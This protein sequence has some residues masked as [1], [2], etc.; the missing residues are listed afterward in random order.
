[1]LLRI[2]LRPLL[3]SIR[4]D[5]YATKVETYDLT[6]FVT[7]CSQV[8]LICMPPS[9]ENICKQSTQYHFVNDFLYR[10][11]NTEEANSRPNVTLR[12]G[13]RYYPGSSF[14][15]EE[16]Y[17]DR[18]QE[19]APQRPLQFR[20]QQQ[21]TIRQR[22]QQ[23]AQPTQQHV[24]VSSP[25]PTVLQQQQPQQFARQSPNQVFHSSEEINIPLQQRRPVQLQTQRPNFQQQQQNE[26]DFRRK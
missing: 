16:E 1:M 19:E 18:E 11:V 26:F 13:D 8:H 22:I 21:P 7:S 12:Y 15:A 3:G 14:E 20:Q 2:V 25:R 6:V 17:T 9:S 5:F 24:L 10:P 23:Q 4:F